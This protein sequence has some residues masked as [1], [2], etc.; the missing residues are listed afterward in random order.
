MLTRK[1]TAHFDVFDTVLEFPRRRMN[2]RKKMYFALVRILVLFS[3][4]YEDIDTTHHSPTKSI[5][6]IPSKSKTV[7]DR[8]KSFDSMNCH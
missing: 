5:I 1:I 3:I 8:A 7:I 2:K 6:R 4:K